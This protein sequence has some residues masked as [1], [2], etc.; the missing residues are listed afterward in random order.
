MAFVTVQT[1]THD[2]VCSYKATYEAGRLKD[3]PKPIAGNQGTSIVIEKLFYNLPSRLKSFKTPGQEEKHLLDVVSKYAVHNY[4]IGF[5]LKFSDPKNVLKTQPMTTAIDTIRTVYGPEIA[6]ELL[7]LNLEDTTYKFKCTGFVTKPNFS[8]KK[9]IMLLF[10]NNRLVQSD[11][12]KQMID[13]LYALYLE[14]G[15]K[16]FIYLSL[17]VDPKN[18]DVNVHPTKSTVCFLYEEAIVEKIKVRLDEM[19]KKKMQSKTFLS[20]TILPGASVPSVS[21][22]NSPEVNKSMNKSFNPKDITRTDAKYQKLDKFLQKQEEEQSGGITDLTQI[23]PSPEPMETDF[24]PR[25]IVEMHSL[26]LLM[27]EIEENCLT[28]WKTVLAEHVFVGHVSRDQVLIQQ[29]TELYICNT[30]ELW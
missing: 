16:P 27:D 6:K 19:L 17:S 21:F 10:I 20:Q 13:E 14:R 8:S 25:K 23:Y 7:E 12:M 11:A 29:N 30:E 18:V 22:N 26:E 4:T 28:H 15:G 9:M 2:Q 24:K 5:S 3:D 1:R